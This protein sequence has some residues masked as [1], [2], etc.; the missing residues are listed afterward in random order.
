M[1]VR[2]PVM[3][4]SNMRAHWAK[5]PE[6]AQSYNAF[7]TVPAHI[8][9]FLIKVMMKARKVLDP[10]HEELHKAIEIFNKQ[11]VQHCK[12]HVAFNKKLRELGYEGM[13]DI[14]EPYKADYD[15]F[16]E[17]KSLRFNVAYCEGFEAMGSAAA[18]VYFGDLGEY[19]EDADEDAMNLWKWHLAEE[20]EHREVCADLYRTLYGNGIFAYFYRVWGFLYATKHINDHTTRVNQYLNATDRKNMSPEELKGS[21]AREKKLNRK[22]ALASIWR[23]LPVFSPFY[24]PGKKE[25]SDDMRAVLASYPDTRS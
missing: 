2:Y 19:L 24:D 15:R 14:E 6:F 12:Q 11:E 21:L 1:K 22:N 7:S 9:P 17:E 25:M 20:F 16:L 13:A 4:F 23:L 8:E 18:Q 10:K 3:D 5:V